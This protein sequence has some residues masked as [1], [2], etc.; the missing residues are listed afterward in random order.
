MPK[1]SAQTR[2]YIAVAADQLIAICR[3]AKKG[4]SDAED[5]RVRAIGF[6]LNQRGGWEA[7]PVAHEDLNKLQSR[8]GL[9]RKQVEDTIQT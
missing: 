1:I 5:E 7:M 4:F 9:K 3:D 8:Y 2:G 6:N